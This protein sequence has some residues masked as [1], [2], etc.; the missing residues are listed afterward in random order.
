VC[1]LKPHRSPKRKLE[2]EP[3]YEVVLEIGA[4]RGRIGQ[5]LAVA[6]FI[7]GV[8]GHPMLILIGAFVWFGAAQEAALSRNST[9]SASSN[10]G[11]L[12]K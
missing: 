6:F 3:L 4:R 5:V 9:A 10:A 7:V 8:A 11:A 1:R 2:R 12:R